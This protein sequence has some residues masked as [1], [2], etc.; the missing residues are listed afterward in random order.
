VN[1][2]NILILLRFCTWILYVITRHNAWGPNIISELKI[3]Y[4]FLHSYIKTR[5]G[6][7]RIYCQYWSFVQ[8]IYTLKWME[9]SDI[10]PR[11]YCLFYVYLH[12]HLRHNI[13][14]NGPN[15]LWVL[16]FC[17]RILYVV[18]WERET[19]RIMSE[20]IVWVKWIISYILTSKR[21]KE[22]HEYIVRF[23]VIYKN[24]VSHKRER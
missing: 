22:N 23:E 1:G 19:E 6:K 18:K 20:H 17:S 2:P 24:F 13:R 4:I 11:I 7:S 10:E 8:E 14:E 15:I 3:N 16:R 9:A 12:T 5:E 21:E